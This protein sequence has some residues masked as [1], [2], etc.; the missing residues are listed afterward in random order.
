MTQKNITSDNK[1][2][3]T[4]CINP[5]RNQY[6]LSTDIK[7]PHNDLSNELFNLS[8]LLVH[9]FSNIESLQGYYLQA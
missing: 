5:L 2:H 8:S 4:F 1:R 3:I 6:T 9:A 7:M